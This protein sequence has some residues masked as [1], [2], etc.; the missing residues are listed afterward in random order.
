MD[1]VIIAG[2]LGS[3]KTTLIMNTVGRISD[4]IGKKITII[5]NDF[6]NIGIDG[7][8]MENFGLKVQ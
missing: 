2:F 4:R 6:G 1:R 5:V 7:K 3:G 8:V